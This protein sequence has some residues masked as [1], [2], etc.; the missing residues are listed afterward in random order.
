MCNMQLRATYEAHI[1]SSALHWGRA[2]EFAATEFRRLSRELFAGSI[3][4]MPVIIG[5]TA[6]GACLGFTRPAGWLAFPR[7]TLAPEVFSGNH[8]TRGG[9]LTVSDTIVH[10]MVHAALI[11]RGEDPRHNEAPWCKLITELSPEVLSAEITARPVRAR[12]IPNPD[13]ETDPSAPKTKVARVPDD[14]CLT[15]TGLAG[16]PL[17]LRPPGYYSHQDPIPVPS[18]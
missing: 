11:L 3:P 5:L 2:G 16:W 17:S 1:W 9:P 6:Y 12:R 14:G 15:R 7:I 10:E 4:P 18:C 8:R 13:R